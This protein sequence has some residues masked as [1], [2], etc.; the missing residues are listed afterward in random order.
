MTCSDEACAGDSTLAGWWAH[1]HRPSLPLSAKCLLVFWKSLLRQGRKRR[2]G[3]EEREKGGEERGEEEGGERG[4]GGASV[5]SRGR[6][7]SQ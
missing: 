1:G 3:G 6:G 7:G 4:E 2:E 5:K